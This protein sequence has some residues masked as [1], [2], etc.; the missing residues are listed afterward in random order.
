MTMPT[1]LNHGM[2]AAAL[3]ALRDLL[4]GG[5]VKLADGWQDLSEGRSFARVVEVQCFGHP[6]ARD[7][8][9]DA[10][11]DIEGPSEWSGNH[12]A[13]RD[14]R[15]TLMTMPILLTERIETSRVPAPQSPA[16]PPVEVPPV[17]FP[18]PPA[19]ADRTAY[20]CADHPDFVPDSLHH[21]REHIEQLHPEELAGAEGKSVCALCGDILDDDN[22]DDSD[23]HECDPG[24]VAR[25]YVDADPRPLLDLVLDERFGPA[26]GP[27]API[28]IVG[29]PGQSV[30]Q[31]VER[32][33]NVTGVVVVPGTPV[34]DDGSVEAAWSRYAR[35]RA[36]HYFG[37][38]RY[39]TLADA[40]EALKYWPGQDMLNETDRDL[41]AGALVDPPRVPEPAP[42]PKQRRRPMFIRV[43]RGDGTVE[44]IAR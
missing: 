7:A 18:P 15:G 25:R 8:I 44:R 14:W 1:S 21:L 40:Y 30:D 3:A 38:K 41:V 6:A 34:S 29:E 22:C 31:L 39:P 35:A 12:Y 23:T 28:E 17:A 42:L 43:G 27:V 32:Y 13:Y 9:L 37:D 24:P 20:A 2:I 5:Y 33:S 36:L 19:G 10:M 16:D 4:L 11:T 26:R